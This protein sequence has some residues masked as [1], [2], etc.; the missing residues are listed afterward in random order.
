MTAY[1]RMQQQ[2]KCCQ[3][4]CH[5]QE[6]RQQQGTHLLENCRWQWRGY[7][8]KQGWHWNH[9]QVKNHL[10]QLQVKR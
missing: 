7:R 6:N 2:V 4:G 1:L 3:Q 5:F 10:S 8:L 9:L